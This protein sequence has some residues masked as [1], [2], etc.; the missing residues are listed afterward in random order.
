MGYE[1]PAD[2]QD[3]NRLTQ[4]RLQAGL[5]QV[6]LAAHV[7]I[8]QNHCNVIETGQRPVFSYQHG[9]TLTARKLAAH[10]GLQPKDLFPE[11]VQLPELDD[12]PCRAGP[13]GSSDQELRSLRPD[14]LL[15]LL[16]AAGRRR[17]VQQTV[18]SESSDRNGAIWE[19]RQDGNTLQQTAK[20]FGV[21]R[22]RIRQIVDRVDE[23]I[24]TALRDQCQPP[25]PPDI[26][27]P[28]P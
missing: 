16:E 28:R 19:M 14:V 26:V 21:T 13:L 24:T 25:T 8:F 22:E 10:F 18:L 11:P 2:Q 7:G 15:E 1:F 3:R 17:R 23:R 9:W 27:I 12:Q 5:T 4:V 20:Q 6:D